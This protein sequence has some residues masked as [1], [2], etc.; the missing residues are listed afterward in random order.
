MR[1]FAPIDEHTE[2]LT[3]SVNSKKHSHTSLQPT[4]YTPVGLYTI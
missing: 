4:V 1:V 2:T 3:Y